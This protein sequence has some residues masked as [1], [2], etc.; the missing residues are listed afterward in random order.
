LKPLL[1]GLAFKSGYLG[2]PTFQFCSCTMLG[3]HCTWCFRR[4]RCYLV[5]CIE[6]P[7]IALALS[8]R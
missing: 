2:G 6:G 5:L 7:A 3:W 8:A 1:L 4:C